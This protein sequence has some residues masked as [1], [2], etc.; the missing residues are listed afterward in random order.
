M[1]RSRPARSTTLLA[2]LVALCFASPAFAHGVGMSQF[3]LIVD[4]TDIV[5]EWEIHLKDALMVAGL[6]S[7]M[8]GPA[9]FEAVKTRERAV[10]DYMEGKLQVTADSVAVPLHLTAAPV[11]WQPALQYLRFHVEAQV[12]QRPRRLTLRYS[13]L[14]EREP[15][16]RGYFSV[17]DAR[18]V[19]AG[20]LTPDQPSVSFDVR[21]L[22]ILPAF[23]EFAREGVFH[24]WTGYDHMLFLFAL[25]LPAALVRVGPGWM[26]RQGLWKTGREVMKVVTAFT[27]AHTVTL[28]LGFF[29]VVS[30][31]SR[32]VETAIAISVFAAAWNNLR[33]FLPGRAWVMAASFGLVHG[34]GFAGVLRNLMLPTHARG[35]A[36]GA[37]N[38]GVEIGQLGIVALTLPL[39]YLLSRRAFYPRFVMG[40]GS[41]LISWLAVVWV[42]ERAFGMQ[43]LAR[44]HF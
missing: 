5:G 15:N 13:L 38:I 16:H 36:L 24:I 35:L 41:L 14:F 1:R 11:E 34:L 19:N 22:H 30:I 43:L 29:G 39:L 10:R 31:S 33:P 42:I 17:E 8:S 4:R 9:G 44:I 7:S 28:C 3:H 12:A 25:L 26:P 23:V 27:A 18:V 6:D 40:I 37:F 2:A 21:Q 32:I 20:V